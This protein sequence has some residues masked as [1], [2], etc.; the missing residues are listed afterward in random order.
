[1][2]LFILSAVSAFISEL[3]Q[4]LEK[5]GLFVESTGIKIFFGSAEGLVLFAQVREAYTQEQ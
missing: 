1:L 3:T 2:L 5:E 4:V